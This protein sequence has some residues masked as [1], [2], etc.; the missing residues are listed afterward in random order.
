[1][2]KRQV[3][4]HGR[5]AALLELG[6]GFNPDLTGRENIYINGAILGLSSA[7]IDTLLSDIIAFADIGDYIDQ[8]VKTYSCLLYTSRCV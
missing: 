4:T 8:P 7:R 6:S 1:M 2:Y 3:Y 5:V